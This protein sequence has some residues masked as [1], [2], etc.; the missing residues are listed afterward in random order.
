MT[1]VSR[2]SLRAAANAKCRS[3]IYD[4]MARGTWREQVADCVSANCPLHPVRPVPR[5]CM[6]GGQ[7][8]PVQLAT[9]RV[10][11]AV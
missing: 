3:C 10:K 11:L 5:N 1:T 4:P 8:C 6:S 9:V 7:I 2:L